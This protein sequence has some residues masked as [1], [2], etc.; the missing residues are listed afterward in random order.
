MVK[1]R[2]GT[3][4]TVN[5]KDASWMTIDITVNG[6]DASWMTISITVN[7]KECVLDDY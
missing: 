2:P 4:I 1:M 6:K 5:G 3:D 7:G